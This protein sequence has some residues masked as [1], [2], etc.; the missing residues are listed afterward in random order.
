MGIIILTFQ[1]D[2]AEKIIMHVKSL[3]QTLAY[4]HSPYV[5]VVIVVVD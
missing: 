3:A 1:G 2:W 5:S 4:S